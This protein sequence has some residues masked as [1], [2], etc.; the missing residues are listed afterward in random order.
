MALVK[1]A[2]CLSL[3]LKPVCNLLEFVSK[4]IHVSHIVAC[5]QVHTDAIDMQLTTISSIIPSGVLLYELKL[6]SNSN[7]C[8]R[9]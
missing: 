6:V 8:T 4:T 3:K 7:N 5:T 2:L 9:R 1:L